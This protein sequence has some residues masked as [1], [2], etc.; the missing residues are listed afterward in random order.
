MIILLSTLKIQVQIDSEI[1]PRLF[2]KFVPKSKMGGTGLGLLIS[3][4]IIETMAV[5]Y[6]LKIT[7]M[8]KKVQHLVL[9]YLLLFNSL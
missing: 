2:T 1:L 7:K 9:V 5:E 3:K 4:S 6:G 8:V